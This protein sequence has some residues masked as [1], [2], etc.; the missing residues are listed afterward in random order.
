MLI[1]GWCVCCLLFGDLF[2]LLLFLVFV[3]FSSLL[4]ALLL[5]GC[6]ALLFVISL[7]CLV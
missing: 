6:L 3:L 1:F 5:F 2:A 7:F 4:F